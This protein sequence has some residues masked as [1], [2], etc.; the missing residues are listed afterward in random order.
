MVLPVR[1]LHER[2]CFGL[3][4]LQVKQGRSQ[5]NVNVKFYDILSIKYPSS[6]LEIT[7]HELVVVLVSISRK[8]FVIVT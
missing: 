1:V 4:I 6:V 3:L 2:H 7:V 8:Q 5:G